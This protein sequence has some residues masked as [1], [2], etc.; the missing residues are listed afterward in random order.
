M[1]E[2]EFIRVVLSEDMPDISAVKEK[3]VK[4]IN[5]EEKNRKE[6][7]N[8]EYACATAVIIVA[9]IIICIF[10]IK[11][12]RTFVENKT[13]NNDGNLSNQNDGETNDSLNKELE[14]DIVK[15]SEING[16]Y[17]SIDEEVTLRISAKEG[18]AFD[19]V[20][21]SL[22]GESKIWELGEIN[23]DGVCD[24]N[25]SILGDYVIYCYSG[26]DMI[27]ITDEVQIEYEL[28]Y[29]DNETKIVPVR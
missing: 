17:I 11:P 15:Y 8:I 16:A 6:L 20:Y 7:K 23:S 5:S 3:C 2:R 18:E 22:I 24:F 1:K 9:L 13:G 12:L 14:N 4:K 27:N 21:I 26:G 10:A 29:S 28:S 19:D 25:V